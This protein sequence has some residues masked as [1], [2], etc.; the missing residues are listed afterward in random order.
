MK[1]MGGGGQC[2]QLMRQMDWTKTPLGP[3]TSWSQTLLTMSS[4]VMSSMHPMA[5]WWKTDPVLI[6]N[7]GYSA[8]IGDR[9]PSALGG[10]ARKYW[11]ELFPQFDSILE[12]VFK[13]ES[14]YTEDGTLIVARYGY[15]EALLI[16]GV[17]NP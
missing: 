1:A 17:S 6:Y 8:L 4:L 2:G 3:I 7:D 11:A 9:H 14:V 13:G 15:T 16:S 12:G 5:L 10:P